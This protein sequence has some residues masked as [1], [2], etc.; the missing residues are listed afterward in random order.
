MVFKYK[1]ELRPES[2]EKGMRESNEPP[3]EKKEED[4]TLLDLLMEVIKAR[5]QEGKTRLAE[6]VE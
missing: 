5:D 6:A 1:G 3:V 2:I 4:K